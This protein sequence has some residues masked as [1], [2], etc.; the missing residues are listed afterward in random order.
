MLGNLLLKNFE[1]VLCQLC[2]TLQWL[3]TTHKS[4][5]LYHLTQGCVVA[6]V[7]TMAFIYKLL[8]PRGGDLQQ[9]KRAYG[10]QTGTPVRSYTTPCVLRSS[11]VVPTLGRS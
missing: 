4:V 7:P 6:M 3:A 8:G 10:V 5:G 9:R 11:Y 1:F 2:V